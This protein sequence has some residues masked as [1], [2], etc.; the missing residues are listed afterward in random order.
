MARR[1]QL[2][3]VVIDTMVIRRALDFKDGTATGHT[4]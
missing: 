1:R 2:G 3:H 4:F